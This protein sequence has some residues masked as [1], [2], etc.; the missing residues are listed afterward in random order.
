MKSGCK[1]RNVGF[2]NYCTSLNIELFLLLLIQIGFGATCEVYSSFENL[3][4]VHHQKPQLQS[5]GIFFGCSV[6]IICVDLSFDAEDCKNILSKLIPESK[7][8]VEVDGIVESTGECF[9]GVVDFVFGLSV[10]R[11]Y[12]QFK[13]E[14]HQDFECCAE[15][16]V[17][18][19]HHRHLLTY[20]KVADDTQR[21]SQRLELEIIEEGFIVFYLTEAN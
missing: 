18:N 6:S 15:N 12:L 1:R 5:F 13:L 20:T 9:N 11:C 4:F 10:W 8:C 2:Q 16:N 14:H 7:V 21:L 19:T 17:Q 3:K